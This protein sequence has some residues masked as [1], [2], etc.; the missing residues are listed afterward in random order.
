[1]CGQQ[2]N[3]TSRDVVCQSVIMWLHLLVWHHLHHKL[4]SN[5]IAVIGSTTINLIV[6]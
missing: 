6:K 3:N 1:M 2:H 4:D 5:T